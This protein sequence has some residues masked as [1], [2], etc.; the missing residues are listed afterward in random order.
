MRGDLMEI[1]QDVQKDIVNF[2]A[3]QNQMNVLQAQLTQVD[4]ELRAIS[5]AVSELESTEDE[6]A[7]K[8]VGPIMVRERKSVLIADLKERSEALDVRK[9]NIEKKVKQIEARLVEL[10]KKIEGALAKLQ[11]VGGGAPAS[12]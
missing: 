7:Y 1:P 11:Q 9:K 12:E 6:F 10:K 4:A 5:E 2:Q 8:V 3:L